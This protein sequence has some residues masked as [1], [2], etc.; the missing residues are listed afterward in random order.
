MAGGEASRRFGRVWGITAGVLSGLAAFGLVV[1]FYRWRWRRDRRRLAELRE[2]FRTIYRLV[3]LPADSKKVIKPVG[4]ETRVGFYGWEATPLCNDGL[5]FLQGLTP[6]WQVVWHAGFRLDHLEKIGPKPSSQYDY[7]VPYWVE[8]AAPAP[9]PYP[10]EQIATPTMG[11]PHHSGR[12]FPKVPDL[13]NREIW[14][15]IVRW[16]LVKARESSWRRV[17]HFSL[18]C[19][20]ER[21]K[22]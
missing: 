5:I 3:A 4:A 10:I 8:R 15:R 6:G 13:P 9:C 17:S 18:H 21:Q 2:K 7:W 16:A 22:I 1:E 14:F 12:Y 20:V 11:L 19:R